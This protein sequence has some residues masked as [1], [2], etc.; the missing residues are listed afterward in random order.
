M[1]LKQLIFITGLFISQLFS[2]M[3]K[4]I[5]NKSPSV[6]IPINE[7]LNKGEIK[8][9]IKG[10]P[11]FN[12]ECLSFDIS[13]KSS[14][15]LCIHFEAGQKLNS[16]S[17]NNQNEFILK[18]KTVCIP[19]HQT[20]IEAGHVLFYQNPKNSIINED[21]TSTELTTKKW[22][23]LSK[24]IEENDYPIQAI[25]A[26]IWC[27]TDNHPVSS[28][29]SED[30]KNI[31]LL[32]RT[33]SEI[34]KNELPWYYF[35]SSQDTTEIYPVE[36]KNI[37]GNI[38]F[39]V[40][41]STIITINIRNEHDEIMTTLIKESSVGPGYHKFSINTSIRTWTK[42]TYT[43]FVYEDYSKVIARKTFEL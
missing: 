20:L 28:I 29:I 33:V 22:Q 7:L 5:E 31:Q 6:G 27:I 34:Q 40:N 1:Q 11:T 15:T 30:K 19:P 14:D 26:A 17:K 8:V 10:N 12:A 9:T 25:Q 39:Y 32:R 16:T 2:S 18:S 37:I 42:G 41:S 4:S 3:V 21:S 24:I 43:V 23:K 36:N 35:T 38:E 13:N